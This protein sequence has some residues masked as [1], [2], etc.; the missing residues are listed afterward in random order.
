MEP[1][2]GR[3]RRLHRRPSGEAGS[4]QGRDASKAVE[5]D[6]RATPLPYSLARLTHC[7]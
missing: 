7:Y 3:E 4:E 5:S 1:T 2:R 6:E